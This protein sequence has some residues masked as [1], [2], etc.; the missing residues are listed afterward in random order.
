[1]QYRSGEQGT[2]IPVRSD[3]FYKLGDDWY[4]NVRGG[5]AFGPFRCREEAEKALDEFLN[6]AQDYTG[7]VR[8]FGSLRALR[9]R[10]QFRD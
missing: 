5:K 7:N 6:P 4:F 3:R 10:K 2:P 9:W 8:P 1:M